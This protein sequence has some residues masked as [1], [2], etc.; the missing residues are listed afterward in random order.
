MSKEYN[1]VTFFEPGEKDMN[2]RAFK[3]L[4]KVSLGDVRFPF[5]FFLVEEGGKTVVIPG[6]EQDRR[7]TLLKAFPD[8]NPEA[9]AHPCDIEGDERCEGD[10]SRFNQHGAHFVC[11]PMYDPRDPG[12]AFYSCACSDIS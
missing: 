11:R 4:R 9:A 6:T 2:H 8:I 5:G 1:G 3:E 12:P 7:K 10:C